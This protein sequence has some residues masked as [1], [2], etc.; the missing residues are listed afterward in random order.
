MTVYDLG[1]LHRIV[2]RA[3]ASPAPTSDIPPRTG[4]NQ[5][6]SR[7]GPQHVPFKACGCGVLAG[8]SCDC[9]DLAAQ[10]E[11]HLARPIFFRF[12]TR[13]AA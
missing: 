8:E 4:D 13:R 10:L 6:P 12:D 11:A 5:V 9:A 2:D 1:D 7:I 3:N